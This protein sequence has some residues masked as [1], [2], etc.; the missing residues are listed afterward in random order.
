MS[1]KSGICPECGGR[2][3][4]QRRGHYSNINVMWMHPRLDVYVC[5]D[6]GYLAEFISG[7]QHLKHV[8]NNWEAVNALPKRKNDERDSDDAEDNPP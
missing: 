8:R 1:M 2:E 5:G 4:F 6:C 3:V 7:E